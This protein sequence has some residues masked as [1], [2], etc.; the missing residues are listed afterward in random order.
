MRIITFLAII[1]F[2]ALISGTNS[3]CRGKKSMTQLSDTTKNRVGE[4]CNIPFKLPRFL[5]N[6]MKQNEMK[7]EWFAARLDCEADADSTHVNFDVNIRIRRDSLI[8]MNITDP[9]LGI[10]AA[11]III[12]TDSVKF[13]NL[14]NSSCFRG[15]FAYLSQILQTEVDFEM[16]QSL[17]LGNSVAFYDEDEK[18]KGSIDQ[19]QCQ[20]QLSTVRK[21]KLRRVLEG[22][23]QLE[24][25][26]QTITLDA[27]TFKILTIFFIDAQSRNFRVDYADFRMEDS[28]LFPHK[29]VYYAKGAQKTATLKTSYRKITFNQRQQFPFKF[30]DDCTPILVDPQ[31]T[32]GQH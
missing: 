28:L 10:P 22:Q 32:P 6:E 19:Q 30:P 12:S 17:L 2:M 1:V 26:L 18:L 21:R 24:E 20:Y 15:D 9:I 27:Q 25:P 3:S 13:V 31:T 8:W 16:M 7:F 14:L 4:H 11:R 5:A 23:V 29:A